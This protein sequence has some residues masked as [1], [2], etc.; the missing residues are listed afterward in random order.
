VGDNEVHRTLGV[1]ASDPN[2][3]EDGSTTDDSTLD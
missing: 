1:D 3:D 2:K